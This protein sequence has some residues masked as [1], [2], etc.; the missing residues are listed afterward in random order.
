MGYKGVDT[1]ELV[2]DGLRLIAATDILG[3][4]AGQGLL[5]DDGRRRG[6]PRQR[7]GTWRAGCRH[8]GVRAGCSTTR[9]SASRSASRSPSTRQCRSGFADMAVKVEAS[10]QMMVM[11]ARKKDSGERND[12]EAG[13]AKYLAS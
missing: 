6:R 9:S 12:L 8:P 3:R 10:H 13:M 7:R 1:T 4:R 2:M 11:A 5:P